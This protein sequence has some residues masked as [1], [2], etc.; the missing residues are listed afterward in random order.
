MDAWQRASHRATVAVIE[1]VG[2]AVRPA[3]PTAAC[4]G[5]LH[6]HAGLHSD[7]AELAAATIAAM[8]GDDPI[9]V[10]SAGCGAA[11]KEYGA[12]LGTDEAARFATRVRDVHEWVAERADRLPAATRRV[13]PVIVQDP[14]HLRHVQRVEQ[15]VRTVLAPYADIVELDD[16]GLC[17]GAGGAYSALQPELAGEI[18][19][20][21]VGSIDRAVAVSGATVLASANPGCAM[22]LAGT[23]ERV[24]HPMDLVAEAAAL[25]DGR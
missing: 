2:G 23:V 10:N 14:C 9:L 16:L 21:K 22:Q 17:C 25:L 20:R 4:C 13:G 7:A 24:A 19:E 18:R 8:P 3:P 11:L 1:A 5:A 6:V 15:P 12:L